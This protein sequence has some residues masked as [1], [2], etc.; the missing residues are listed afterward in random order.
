MQ[1]PRNISSSSSSSVKNRHHHRKNSSVSSIVNLSPPLNDVVIEKLLERIEHLERKDDLREQ[2]LN[3]VLSS[4]TYLE[5]R[6]DTLQSLILQ[7]P[8]QQPPKEEYS[9]E[10]NVAICGLIVAIITLVAT[11]IGIVYTI[12]TFNSKC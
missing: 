11:W 9:W 12:K 5:G 7:Q 4:N 3:A 10:K 2:Q 8:L 1:Q 6:V